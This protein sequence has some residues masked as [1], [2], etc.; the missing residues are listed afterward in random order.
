MVVDVNQER[1]DVFPH[2]QNV[3]LTF[4]G[5]TV[6]SLHRIRDY[7]RN[8]GQRL[9]KPTYSVAKETYEEYERLHQVPIISLAI[10]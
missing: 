9:R 5:M 6:S 8:S 4:P 3:L 10:S 7:I 2:L 1:E